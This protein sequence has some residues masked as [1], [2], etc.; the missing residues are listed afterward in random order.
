M[1]GVRW[2]IRFVTDPQSRRKLLNENQE[3]ADK[4]AEDWRET[5]RKSERHIRDGIRQGAQKGRKDAEHEASRLTTF[6]KSQFAQIAAIV[7]SVFAVNTIVQFT[8][9]LVQL[10]LAGGE[11]AAKFRITFGEAQAEMKSFLD[12]FSTMAGLS[13]RQGEDAAA[14]IAAMGRGMGF[15][16]QEAMKLS[17]QVLSTAGDLTAFN[18]VPIEQTIRAVRSAIVGERE[19]LKT[20]GVV[21]QETHVQQRAMEMSGKKNAEALTQ[22]E[23]AAATLQLIMERMGPAQG[24][25]VRESD[26]LSAST[27]STSAAW[28][29]FK[30]VLGETLVSGESNGVVMG[31]LRDTFISMTEWVR[32]NAREIRMWAAGTVAVFAAIVRTLYG[33]GRVFKNTIEVV[34]NFMEVLLAQMAIEIADK[35]NAVVGWMNFLIERANRLLPEDRQI[36]LIAELSTAGA[37]QSLR[38]ARFEMEKNN[39]QTI[40]AVKNIADAW[41]DVY[42]AVKAAGRQVEEV[43]DVTSQL[44]EDSKNIDT[45]VLTGNLAGLGRQ[46]RLAGDRG[47][48]GVSA[49]LDLSRRMGFIRE[50]DPLLIDRRVFENNLQALT[51]LIMAETQIWESAFQSVGHGMTRAFEDAFSLLFQ[52]MSNLGA[53]VETIAQGMTAAL[54]G[55]VADF[56]STKVAENIANAFEYFSKAKAAAALAVTYPPA[57]AAAGMYTAAAKGALVSAGKWAIVA[58][59][60]AAASGAIGGSGGG[61]LGRG[62]LGDISRID[63]ARGPIKFEVIVDGIDPDNPKHQDLTAQSLRQIK[64]RYPDLDVEYNVNG[65]KISV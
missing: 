43:Q 29:T 36:G 1:P 21:V 49:R 54:V 26:S 46:A 2:F 60:A 19:A 23:K 30:E 53:F 16:T 5:G 63:G 38:E 25:L 32:T 39:R 10:G 33:V 50:A 22:Q 28:M 65:R 4:A 35:V 18:D 27:R 62:G 61:G 42:D 13:M 6:L 55:S 59:G 3:T 56:A 15:T 7:G 57:A 45:S 20:L 41:L 48:R 17:Q 51:E 31:Q 14:T 24:A 64:Q 37:E 52:D 12:E 58:G 9:Q 34:A 11:T 8:K 44:A 47:L 40:E